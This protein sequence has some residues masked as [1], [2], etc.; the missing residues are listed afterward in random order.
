MKKKILALALSLA[1][2][3]PFA[4]CSAKS[5]VEIDVD[6]GTR[7]GTQVANVKKIDM[8]SPTW[9]YAKG[10]GFNDIEALEQ[11]KNAYG[12][13]AESI[14]MDLAIDHGGIGSL[15]GSPGDGTSET[16]WRQ[17]LEALDYM[18]D[19]GLLPYLVLI[20]V[21][22]YAQKT[23]GSWALAPDL[24]KYEQ[25][26]YNAAK[27]LREREIRI[28]AYETWNEPDLP[29]FFSGS[30]REAID[31]TIA[32]TRGLKRGDPD[33]LV[34]ALG[35]C[36]P[37]AFMDE[38]KKYN[39]DGEQKTYW[40]Y[41]MEQSEASGY[42]PD[43]LSWHFYGG[44]NGKYEGNDDE[45]QNFSYWLYNIRRTLNGYQEGTAEGLGGKR[46]DISTMQQ[47]VT[48]FHPCTNQNSIVDDTANCLPGFYNSFKTLKDATDI[49]RVSWPSFISND[50]YLLKDTS[51]ARSLGFYAMW[52]Y[53]R[54]PYGT[55]S[56]DTGN[57]KL[58]YLAGV[59]KDRAGI[60][61]YN[62]TENAESGEITVTLSCKNLPFDPASLD[63]YAIG[64]EYYNGVENEPVKVLHKSHPDAEDGKITFTVGYR[65][66]Y[67]V[68]F[69]GAETSV[70][71]E[72]VDLGRIVR[73]DYWYPTRADKTPYADFNER[74]MTAVVGMA[75]NAEGQ[76]AMCVTLDEMKGKTIT[77]SYDTYGD[78][79]KSK[80]GSLGV[81]I[82]FCTDDGYE[83]ST[84]FAVK[85]FRKDIALPLGGR[86]AAE[87][88][89][90]MGN[91]MSG[92]YRLD[93]AAWAP[94][95][96]NG[97]I[98]CTFLIGNAGRGATTVF[99]LR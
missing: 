34:T 88:I 27:F 42:M 49:T 8:F 37:M 57:D 4:G 23:G 52:A 84:F 59:D 44:P 1:L 33:A 14:R 35:L 92:T 98:C 60:I 94:E 90:S 63:V 6:F 53:A 70:V 66:S 39:I 36:W 18:N 38:N 81:K 31:M 96:W 73:K 78:A 10:G 58:D 16:E 65:D 71:S 45:M 40:Q 77:L 17:T 79:I 61:L 95:G 15:L 67:Y 74:S 30:V 48:E 26:W 91:G 82:D 21:P 54:L 97:R 28:G 9:S 64:D 68:E 29:S 19:A 25:F 32:S 85:D 41:F 3:V 72:D 55:I 76:S 47:H 13:N 99:T 87:K 56:V 46:Y 75:D 24:E 50:F 83:N 51:Y 86:S 93:L 2:C 7:D 89:V 11:L 5:A 22:E 12:L 43:A 20:G 80:A 62:N 69:N